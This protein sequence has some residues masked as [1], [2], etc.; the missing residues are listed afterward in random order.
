MAK[1]KL[2]I[3]DFL[4]APIHQCQVKIWQILPFLPYVIQSMVACSAR[5]Y[6]FV[7][8]FRQRD[9]LVARKL[10]KSLMY[11]PSLRNMPITPRITT[12]YG[13]FERIVLP[14]NKIATCFYSF[15]HFELFTLEC[16]L[17][18]QLLS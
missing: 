17:K 12:I 6:D 14:E 4:S 9:I 3:S 8:L 1:L 16:N 11:T 10:H 7:S 2:D 18:Q 15:I 5:E 13:C